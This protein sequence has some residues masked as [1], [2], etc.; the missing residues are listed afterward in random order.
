MSIARSVDRRPSGMRSSAHPAK[1]TFRTFDV[2]IREM[3][4]RIGSVGSTRGPNPSLPRRRPPCPGTLVDLGACSGIAAT[5]ASAGACHSPA[6]AGSLPP[7]SPADRARRLDCLR[8]ACFARFRRTRSS[9][10]CRCR[11]DRADCVRPWPWILDVHLEAVRRGEVLPRARAHRRRA[12][13]HVLLGVDF[14]SD[15]ERC[16][17]DR[18]DPERAASMGP[19]IVSDEERQRA[20]VGQRELLAAS[21]GPSIVIDGEPRPPDI[22]GR[23]TVRISAISATGIERQGHDRARRCTITLIQLA[24]RAPRGPRSS[25]GSSSLPGAATTRAFAPSVVRTSREAATSMPC[26]PAP[27]SQGT[28]YR[29]KTDLPARYSPV[30]PGP[31]HGDAS[32]TART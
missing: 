17:T 1:V 7:A 15:G 8:A 30:H 27:S 25:H 6:G 28:K 5:G 26:P 18:R 29:S 14:V 20:A 2:K 13:G 3:T 11:K 24:G 16:R 32:W 10:S 12:R 19:S 9:I 21:M 31:L 23:R 4:S 22:P